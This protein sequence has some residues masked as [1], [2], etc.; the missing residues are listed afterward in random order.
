M[1]IYDVDETPGNHDDDDGNFGKT[2][3]FTSKTTALNVHHA[4]LY[5]RFMDVHCTNTTCQPPN[6]TFYGV[7]E[8]TRTNQFPLSFNLDKVIKNSTLG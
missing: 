7:C 4:F 3:V 5:V 2:I 1:H 6:T 8:H